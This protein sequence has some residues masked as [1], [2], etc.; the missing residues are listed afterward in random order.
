MA[1]VT[2]LWEWKGSCQFR[3]LLI[4]S[5]GDMVCPW[6]R[7]NSLPTCFSVHKAQS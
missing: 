4:R 3:S 5:E 6:R 2:A 1:R 7:G